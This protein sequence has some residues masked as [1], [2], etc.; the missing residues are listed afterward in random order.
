MLIA[1]MAAA[2]ATLSL[3]GTALILR[4]FHRGRQALKQ[5][6][7]PSA[8]T[9]LVASGSARGVAPELVRS[10]AV[11]Q[12]D[13]PVSIRLAHL[14]QDTTTAPTLAEETRTV[15]N[16]DARALSGSPPPRHFPDTWLASLAVGE[17]RPPQ[18]ILMDPCVRPSSRDLAPLSRALAGSR[19]GMVAACPCPVP[20]AST[21]GS[22]LKGRLVADLVPI[23]QG[24]SGAP[25]L[26]HALTATRPDTLDAAVADPLALNR[27]SLSTAAAVSAPMGT[28]LL[29][30]LP[31][32]CTTRVGTRSLADL[33]REQ[34]LFLSRHAPVRYALAG[35]WL[36][37]LPA[38]LAAWLLTDHVAVPM[39]LAVCTASRLALA[40]T[41][42]RAILGNQ[43]AS[44]GFILSPVRDLLGL[45]LLLWSSLGATVGRDDQRFR[46][47]RGGVL[48]PVEGS[49]EEDF[50]LIRGR[51]RRGPR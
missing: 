39:A 35:A 26:P 38:T 40:A 17:E 46:M 47:R 6:N 33:F 5:A 16:L 25:G 11:A 45:G 15:P 10:T 51:S 21:G 24:L 29:L 3:L 7:E 4:A 18:W 2:L 1:L 30:P 23:L 36:A 8:F 48:T 12:H 14:P 42:S 32:G 43:I 27:P 19:Q 13:G 49:L 31:V 37:S 50:R 34:T 28:S 9:V 22:R 20:G 41:W 44:L